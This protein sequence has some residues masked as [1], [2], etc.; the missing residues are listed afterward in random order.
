M[1]TSGGEGVS[2]SQTIAAAHAQPAAIPALLIKAT[3]AD[4]RRGGT[5]GGKRLQSSSGRAAGA[6]SPFRP[7]RRQA[8]SKRFSIS[9]T[10]LPEPVM[11]EPK[12]G[13]FSRPPRICR[14]MLMT[15]SARCGWCS[16]SHSLN[17]GFT[18]FGRRRMM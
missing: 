7:K 12:F 13:S 17:S 10:K 15:C 3:L 8:R 14:T 5:A 4:L 11:R 9:S 1:S 18:S 16:A 2:D 6:V